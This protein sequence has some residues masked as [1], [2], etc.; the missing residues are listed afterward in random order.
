MTGVL[1]RE[2]AELEIAHTGISDLKVVGSMHERKE[3][4]AR[5]SD[6]FVVMPGG[7]GT[8][9]EAI[10]I[11]TWTQLGIHK[12]AIGLLDVDGFF[13]QLSGFLDHTVAEG[14][15]KP[16]HRGMLL[17]SPDVKNLLDQLLSTEVPS[18]AKW[19]DPIKA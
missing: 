19:I 12:K 11:L 8:L 17:A 13:D 10:E 4:M 16:V 3:T 18:I 6:A 15:L 5:L 1:P 2:L 14:F 7:I 9:E